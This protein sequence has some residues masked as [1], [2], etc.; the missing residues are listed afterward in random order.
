MSK[1]E[2]SLVSDVVS[3]VTGKPIRTSCSSASTYWDCQRKWWFQKVYGLPSPGSAATELGGEVHEVLE[4]YLITGKF[5]FGSKAA[6]VAL[7]GIDSLPTGL[8]VDKIETMVEAM[9]GPIPILGFI[10]MWDDPNWIGDHKTCGS[11]RWSKTKEQLGWNPQML[12]Y[13]YLKF[14]DD[15]PDTVRMTHF[16]YLTKG[17]PEAWRVDVE[18]PWARTE[19]IWAR[20]VGAAKGM[21]RLAA[22]EDQTHVPRTLSACS[23]YGGCPF[24]DRCQRETQS[25]PT[26]TLS[27]EAKMNIKD[28][29]A[30]MKAAREAGANPTTAAPK[31]AAPKAAAPKAAAPKAAAPKRQDIIPP[32]AAPQ[33]ILT[34]ALLDDVADRYVDLL[35]ELAEEGQSP[36]EGT[37][38]RMASREGIPD[39]ALDELR[40]RVDGED[41]TPVAELFPQGGAAQ[42]EEPAPEPETEKAPGRTQLERS[43]AELAARKAAVG[44]VKAEAPK[45]DTTPSGAD[46]FSAVKTGHYPVDLDS[47]DID[48][49]MVARAALAFLVRQGT[50]AEGV[51]EL[52][53]GVFEFGSGRVSTYF[54]QAIL[55]LYSGREKSIRVTAN[56][57]KKIAKA[58]DIH[59][60]WAISDMA[61]KAPDLLIDVAAAAQAIQAWEAGPAAP[62]AETPK[63][64]T[65][66]AETP[67]A[68]T[69]KAETPSD[70]SPLAILYVDCAPSGGVT[71]AGDWLAPVF[72]KVERELNIE[73]YLCTEYAEGLAGATQELKL[74]LMRGEMVYPPDGLAILSSTP[75]YSKMIDVLAKAAD[76]V[77][78]ARR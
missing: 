6:E 64:E 10:D 47:G 52:G 54:R 68:E 41:S 32:D 23:K 2:G 61:K 24:K 3:A 13:A 34:D 69:P 39:E 76:V 65:P 15:P 44:S 46:K 59:G 40:A 37:L 18:V 77:V 11:K 63:A 29:I 73:H 58:G 20:M 4:D 75:Y 33:A 56:R 48:Y 31:A 35:N 12:T 42:V 51:T 55:R 5:P 60:L 45:V 43:K 25:A 14:R 74:G 1:R 66:K 8:A 27:R 22:V 78:R 17:T 30:A 38:E 9:C 36:K 7:P 70:G 49:L 16:Y 57:L 26:D 72:A 21:A 62:K 71:E 53:E 28:K 67:K 19:K 50:D